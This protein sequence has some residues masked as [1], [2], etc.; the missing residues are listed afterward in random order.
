MGTINPRDDPS[1]VSPGKTR[2]DEIELD[3]AMRAYDAGF[4]ASE[5]EAFLTKEQRKRIAQLRSP[6]KEKP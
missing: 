5:F 1:D 2:I 6:S 4:G 3:A